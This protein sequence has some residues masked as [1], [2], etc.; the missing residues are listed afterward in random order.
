MI[1]FLYNFAPVEDDWFLHQ[2]NMIVLA[3]LKTFIIYLS[4]SCLCVN[5]I[6][7]TVFCWQ[8]LILHWYI[9]LM[10]GIW[11]G[12]CNIVWNYRTL[13]ALWLRFLLHGILFACGH[14][15]AKC[16]QNPMAHT[17]EWIYGFLHKIK[18]LTNIFKGLRMVA[19]ALWR[20]EAR[21]VVPWSETLHEP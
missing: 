8:R 18:V 12:K 16:I 15:S 2:L 20:S 21:R 4:F 7:L 13:S 17:C 11:G 6:H 10:S 19:R 1:C 9:T 14:L 5:T 3:F